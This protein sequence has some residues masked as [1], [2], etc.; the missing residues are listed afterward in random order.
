MDRK[1]QVFSY[2]VILLFIPLSGL[3]AG[4]LANFM[5]L[6]VPGTRGNGFWYV[7][8]GY[9]SFWPGTYGVRHIPSM[10]L[11]VAILWLLAVSRRSRKPV[12]TLFQVRVVL[13][14]LIILLVILVKI[15]SVVFVAT[16]TD[17]S[18]KEWVS[19]FVYGVLDLGL[20]FLMT[21]LP[22]YRR[23]GATFV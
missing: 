23:R 17:F 21:F 18:A 10:V 14:I 1:N 8:Q 3:A 22:L 9:G 2:I 16:P 20:V 19:L 5:R 6:S 12:V 7:L 4:I 13:L 11:S 15:F